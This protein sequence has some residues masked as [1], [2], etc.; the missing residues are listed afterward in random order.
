MTEEAQHKESKEEML[1]A[2]LGK[3]DE[4]ILSW[5]AKEY[6]AEEKS[7]DW[8]WAL[9]VLAIS[10][11]AASF[12]LHNVLFGVFI[13][14]SAFLLALFVVRKPRA[15]LFAL[16]RKGVLIDQ[17]LYPYASLESYWIYVHPNEDE[18]HPILLL[19]SQGFFTPLISIPIPHNIAPERV[20]EILGDILDLEEHS[21]PIAQ[22][23][24][25]F[26]GF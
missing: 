10:A 11:A 17:A 18:D 13:L 23:V 1:K 21:P 8:F 7:T 16:T 25:E 5:R 6:E 12:I 3:R 20:D 22:R 9:G 15:V 14:I 19:K 24:F 26:F 2:R 4:A